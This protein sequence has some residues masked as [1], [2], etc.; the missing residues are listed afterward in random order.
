VR[1]SSA[2]I[3]PVVTLAALVAAVPVAG[4]AVASPAPFSTCASDGKFAVKSVDVEPQPLVPGKKVSVAVSGTLA[5]RLTDGT[6]SA[7]VRYR[8]IEVAQR[9]GS[10]RDVTP[11][12][13]G[14]G[15]VT[16][17]A[18][19]EVPRRTPSGSYEL[20]FSAADQDGATL[21]CLVVPF[22]VA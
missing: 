12:P 5:E 7:N 11:L 15:P 10:L 9:T 13:A 16:V 20:Q 4:P 21:T 19:L 18:T 8:G 22:R 2:R 1:T 14:P 17:G 3:L 6:Y